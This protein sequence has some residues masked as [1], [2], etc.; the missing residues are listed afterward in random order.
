VSLAM[1]PVHVYLVSGIYIKKK[2]KTTILFGYPF[3]LLF[4]PFFFFSF[5]K[6]KGSDLIGAVP[7]PRL[8]MIGRPGCPYNKKKTQTAEK[9]KK[10]DNINRRNVVFSVFNCVGF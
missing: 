2:K 1:S 7:D 6:K 5:I 9:E 3:F 4:S 8:N 10:N